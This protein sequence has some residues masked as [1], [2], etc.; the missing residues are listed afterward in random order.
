[1]MHQYSPLLYEGGFFTAYLQGNTVCFIFNFKLGTWSHVVT[2]SDVLG[3]Y[4]PSGII[5]GNFHG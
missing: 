4:Y 5:N 2:L 3:D 1:M